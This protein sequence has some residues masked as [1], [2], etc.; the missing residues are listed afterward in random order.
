MQSVMNDTSTQ[1]VLAKLEQL[2]T[3]DRYTRQKNDRKII[4]R[5]IKALLPYADH[6]EYIR[7]MAVS[8]GYVEVINILL[9]YAASPVEIK[10]H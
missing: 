9:L 2:I 5:Q 1:Q 8:H 6:I 7:D 10:Q 4:Q 3:K